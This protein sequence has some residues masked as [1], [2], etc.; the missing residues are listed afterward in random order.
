MKSS[1]RIGSGPCRG[2]ANQARA[3]CDGNARRRVG[4]GLADAVLDP[5]VNA[6]HVSLLREKQLNPSYAEQFVR[7]G[8]GTDEVRALGEKLLV[9]A[10]LAELAFVHDK[11]RVGALDGREAVRD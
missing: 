10:A 6:I 2:S 1:S 9:G 8:T 3:N 7:L 11:D 4:G 5:Y